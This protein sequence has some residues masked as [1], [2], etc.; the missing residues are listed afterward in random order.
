[1]VRLAKEALNGVEDGDLEDKYRWEQGF[2]LQ[3]YMTNDSTEARAA[4]RREA[5]RAFRCAGNRRGGTRMN[6]TYTP[7]Q[8]AF[9]AEI[10]EWLAAHV[11]RE[12]LPSFDT[13]A[14]F[15]AHR[16]WERTLHSGRWSMGTWPREL[17]GAA[18]T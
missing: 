14:G 1:M 8:Q 5:R 17:G 4:F 13:E 3:A 7:Q 2:T 10:R 12:R 9:R 18:A 6:L 11:P 15:A 16:E